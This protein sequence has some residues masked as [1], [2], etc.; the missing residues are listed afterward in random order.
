[1]W[2]V[3]KVV[4]G[5]GV[6]DEP[7][8]VEGGVVP[9]HVHDGH[10]PVPLPK[11]LHRLVHLREAGVDFQLLCPALEIDKADR[12]LSV[13][14]FGWKIG[15]VD[16][17]VVRD[18]VG[19]AGAAQLLNRS[20]VDHAVPT[21]YGRLQTPLPLRYGPQKL[22]DVRL[23]AHT[24]NTV[25][26]V[27]INNKEPTSLHPILQCLCIAGLVSEAKGPGLIEDQLRV[28]IRV[29][30]WLL[31]GVLPLQR[32]VD[33]AFVEGTSPWVVRFEAH[34]LG[35]EGGGKSEAEGAS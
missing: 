28:A 20:Q 7:G 12:F 24:V 29:P 19:T 33:I 18:G 22:R 11:L 25:P 32:A 1:M 27:R 17:E 8:G 4:A 2:G 26:K 3:D 15:G 10:E 21:T 13:G 23:A 9:H 35:I 34:V 6:L 16:A 14:I 31:R 5:A 30:V